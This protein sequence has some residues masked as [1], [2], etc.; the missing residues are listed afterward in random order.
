MQLILL[1]LRLLLQLAPNF[2][3]NWIIKRNFYNRPR[4]GTTKCNISTRIIAF[5]FSYIHK[6]FKFLYYFGKQKGFESMLK[7]SP[8]R[9]L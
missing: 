3:A 8:K 5:S 1:K 6:S 9:N 7:T 4:F 2:C